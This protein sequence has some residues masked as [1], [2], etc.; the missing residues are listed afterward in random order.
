MIFEDDPVSFRVVVGREALNELTGRNLEGV[1]PHQVSVLRDK[2]S[3]V[4]KL[5][6]E[7][8]DLDSHF[9][10]QFALGQT[11]LLPQ[12]AQPAARLFA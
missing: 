6:Y 2:T 12:L 3:T 11:A 4:L 8:V 7:S 5:G 1:G 10:S 9:F